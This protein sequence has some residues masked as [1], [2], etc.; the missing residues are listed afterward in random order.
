MT[1]VI[2]A[3]IHLVQS[4]WGDQHDLRCSYETG[5]DSYW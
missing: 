2:H 4:V 1:R 5:N 3:S